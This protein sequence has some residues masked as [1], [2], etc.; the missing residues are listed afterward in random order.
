MDGFDVPQ[1]DD[2]TQRLCFRLW[3]CAIALRGYSLK[4]GVCERNVLVDVVDVDLI[5][6][7]ETGP[8]PRDT[9]AKGTSGTT[10]QCGQPRDAQ[11]ETDRQTLT[12][13]L[14]RAL[15]VEANGFHGCVKYPPVIRCVIFGGD[16]VPCMRQGLRD[17]KTVARQ[18][19]SNRPSSSDVFCSLWSLGCL[20]ANASC[21]WDRT[22]EL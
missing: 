20:L 16:V 22:M 15:L 18:S 6:P 12:L 8:L 11:T 5:I 1:H 7:Y 17:S 4:I 2:P 13:S 3:R 19:K 10:Q 21:Q 14:S 9:E